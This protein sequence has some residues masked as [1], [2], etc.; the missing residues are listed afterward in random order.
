MFKA[1]IG[2]VVGFLLAVAYEWNKRR[3]SRQ[4]HWGMLGAEVSLCAERARNYLG[5]S[6]SAPLYRLPTAAFKV[7]FPVLVAEADLSPREFKSLVEFYSWC[8]DI[9]RGLDN[10]DETAKARNTD[11]L[12]L[13]EKRIDSKCEKLLSNFLEPAVNTLKQHGVSSM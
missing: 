1:L 10:A 9:N 2:V 13:E 11:Q 5:R 6:V 3:L 12:L 4:A 8:E 7:S